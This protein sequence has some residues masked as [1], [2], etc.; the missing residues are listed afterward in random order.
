[1]RPRRLAGPEHWVKSPMV[2]RCLSHWESQA[3]WQ[4]QN[5]WLECRRLQG[6]RAAHNPPPWAPS[7]QPNSRNTDG[8]YLQRG[9]TS[10]GRCPFPPP[11]SL[12]GSRWLQCD[13]P[14]IHLTELTQ[15]HCPES[16]TSFSN[17]KTKHLFSKLKPNIRHS[18]SFHFSSLPS[19]PGMA[20]TLP[21]WDDH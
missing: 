9:D 2:G 4:S 11:S 7:S 20:L 15:T 1:M 17:T 13:Q 19:Q 12:R 5:R 6:D 3:R 10:S 18:T 16:H 8:D 21:A 14:T